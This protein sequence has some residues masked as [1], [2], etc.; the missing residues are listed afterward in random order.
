MGGK[1]LPVFIM[2]VAGIAIAL[3]CIIFKIELIPSVLYISLTLFIFYFIG[4]II[5]KII[6][7]INLDAE[8]RAKEMK[9]EGEEEFS[10][11]EESENSDDPEEV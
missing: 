2:L 4:L 9:K 11:S 1:R 7:K 8:S 3:S 6:S 10:E 5:D